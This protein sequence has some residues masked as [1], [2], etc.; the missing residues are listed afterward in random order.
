MGTRGRATIHDS[1]KTENYKEI[2]QFGQLPELESIK[3]M[4]VIQKVSS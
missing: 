3:V 1:M 2:L 4:R